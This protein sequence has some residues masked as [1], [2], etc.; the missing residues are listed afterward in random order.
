M[1]RRAL[2][3]KAMSQ[4]LLLGSLAACSAPPASPL[5]QNQT[6][7]GLPSSDLSPGITPEAAAPSTE[8]KTA[9]PSSGAQSPIVSAPA[10]SQGPPIMSSPSETVKY[11]L[12]FI[13]GGSPK[14]DVYKFDKSTGTATFLSSTSVPNAT[15]TFLAIHAKKKL[16]FAGDDSN[17]KVKS[18]SVNA[19]TGVLTFLSDASMKDSPTHVSVDTDGNFVFAASYI[20]G[21]VESYPVG[22]DGHLGAPVSDLYAGQNAHEGLLNV[23]G[24]HL[25]VPCLG[26]NYLA[27]YSVANGVLTPSNPATIPT[28]AAGPRHFANH[29]NGKWIY[30]IY[31]NSSALQAYTF[32]GTTLVANGSAV[33]SLASPV[34]GNTG[35]EIQV[36]PN[37]KFVFGSNRGDDSIASFSVSDMGQLTLLKQTKSGGVMPRHFSLDASGAWMTVAHQTSGGVTIFAVNPA[38]GELIPKGT[39]LNYDSAQFAQIVDFTE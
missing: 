11:S 12:L 34:S 14:I 2:M 3:L 38:T 39:A 18:Y 37:G 26:S 23:K 5:Y 31:E 32:D 24:D 33:S 16:L 8:P 6:G 17:E 28:G 27:Q 36:H 22:S 25:W 29:P 30:L 1:V 21:H 7:D 10:T 35:A 19:A 4:G 13:G 15:P 9:N 20:G